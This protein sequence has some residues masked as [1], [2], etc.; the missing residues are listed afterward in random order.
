MVRRRS[1]AVDD[2]KRSAR[3]E[4]V[5]ARREQR[6]EA[7]LNAKQKRVSRWLN[8]KGQDRIIRV[9]R[10][11]VRFNINDHIA[12]PHAGRHIQANAFRSSKGGTVPWTKG[13]GASVRSFY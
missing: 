1:T 11:R 3:K 9:G 4:R 6:A 5:A 13:I 10:T 2:G 8:R 7:R 12:G